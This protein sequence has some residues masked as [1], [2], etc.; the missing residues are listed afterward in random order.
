MTSFEV[1]TS[2]A[3]I[4]DAALPSG[5]LQVRSETESRSD[6]AKRSE[7]KFVITGA[8]F[9]AVRRLLEVNCRRI[10]HHDPVSV[11]RSVY[12]DDDQ[13]SCCYAN[14]NGLG[15]RNKV[16]LRW[17]DSLLPDRTVYLE[18]KWRKSRVTGKHRYEVRSERPLTEITYD[19]LF[20]DLEPSLPGELCGILLRNPRP[21]VLVEYHREHFVS[22]DQ[23]IRLTIDYQLAFYD[24]GGRATFTADFVHRMPD[25]VIL[26]AK[27]PVGTEGRIQEILFPLQ[28]RAARFSK[29]VHGCHA[30]GLIAL[31]R[32]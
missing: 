16:R 31:D 17:Y 5:A 23:Q 1:K 2:L 13:L 14:L 18:F 21:I 27:G 12:L 28:V 29:Y 3:P 24:Q 6:L 8:D 10:V 32:S 9:T 30:L 11:V 19:R 22:W 20:R 7:V 25:V 26:E 4:T 15:I